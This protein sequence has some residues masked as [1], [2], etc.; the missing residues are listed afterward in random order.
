MPNS[1][2]AV[3]RRHEK[4]IQEFSAWNTKLKRR[5]TRDTV[6]PDAVLSNQKQP[7]TELTLTPPTMSTGGSAEVTFVS[8]ISSDVTLGSKIIKATTT[9]CG[10]T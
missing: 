6:L 5:K 8:D 2:L 4:N 7:P 3:C 10:A 9:F 1:I